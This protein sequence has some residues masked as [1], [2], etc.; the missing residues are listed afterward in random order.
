MAGGNPP[1]NHPP[2]ETQTRP[3][4]GPRDGLRKDEDDAPPYHATPPGQ[5]KRPM[6]KL[7]LLEDYTYET[8]KPPPPD[9]GP[10]EAPIQF[11]LSAQIEDDGPPSPQTITVQAFAEAAGMPDAMHCGVNGFPT[12]ADPA[13]M[14]VGERGQVRATET[15]FFT[16][17]AGEG[18]SVTAA[19]MAMS[20]GLGLPYMGMKPA[21]ALRI[22]HMNGEDDE[23]TLGQCREGFLQHSEAITGR[24]LTRADLAP[25]DTMLRTDF[26]RQFTGAEFV[27]RLDRLLTESLAD[28]VLINPLLSF[29]GGE[30][31]AEA[32]NFLR[33]LLGP[34]L[35]RHKCA[36]LIFHHTVKLSR[37][38]WQNMDPTYSGIGGGEV[39]NVP[40][41]IFTLQPT[42]VDGLRRLIVAKRKL[43]DW[44][45]AEGKYTDHAYFRRTDDPT[46]PAWLPVD[47][48]EALE[49][50][51][52]AVKPGGARSGRKAD[53]EDVFAALEQ[54]AMPRTSLLDHLC[55]VRKCSQTVA[56]AALAS[57]RLGE[58]IHEF[59][60]RNEQTGRPELW[61]CMPHH[62][63]QFDSRSANPTA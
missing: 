13:C 3:T 44:K 40:R 57:A 54:H 12:D 36:A 55:R 23:V 28:I 35:M 61:F 56:K 43:A 62:K 10:P 17:S 14:L 11:R 2:P 59:T 1:Q 31:V 48:A 47:H 18:K 38:S 15:H 20:F 45:D 30:I 8:P 21:R 41:S 32:S 42:G 7:S 51:G 50:I 22:L 63:E 19:G 39:A 24:K 26:S 27:A 53:A 16:S 49:L 37:D 4:A 60:T 58:Q 52:E 25:L 29:I 34:L 6:S 9:D 33:V 46:R 5:P